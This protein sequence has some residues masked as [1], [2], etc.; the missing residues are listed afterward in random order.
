MK[1]FQEKNLIQADRQQAI[2][3]RRELP[4]SDCSLIPG[5]GRCSYPLPGNCKG[6]AALLARFASRGNHVF[7]QLRT[8]ETTAYQPTT[9]YGTLLPEAVCE[10]AQ[11]WR[12]RGVR[13]AVDRDGAAYSVSDEESLRLQQRYYST[14]W[15]WLVLSTLWTHDDTSGNYINDFNS[16]C[17][18]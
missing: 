3:H 1:W 13:A 18:S 9:R 11:Q 6:Y 14:F 15:S 7:L 12:F 17:L 5:R 16:V 2:R 8:V 10:N 4:L